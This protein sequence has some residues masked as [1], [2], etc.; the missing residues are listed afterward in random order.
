MGH[1]CWGVG[2][3]VQRDPVSEAGPVEPLIEVETDDHRERAR[4]DEFENSA[5][6]IST[7]CQ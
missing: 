5:D 4:A 1:L 3:F 6:C 2:A 7:A